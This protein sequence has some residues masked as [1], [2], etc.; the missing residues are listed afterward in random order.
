MKERKGKNNLAE[1]SLPE[2]QIRNS[3]KKYRDDSSWK[4]LLCVDT[5]PEVLGPPL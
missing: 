5:K 2:S 4:Q 1:N 3:V